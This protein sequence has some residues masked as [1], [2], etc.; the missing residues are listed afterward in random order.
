MYFNLAAPYG[1]YGNRGLTEDI[2]KQT[3]KTKAVDAVIAAPMPPERVGVA[4]P[5]APGQPVVI[6]AT[7][8][9]AKEGGSAAHPKSAGLAAAATRG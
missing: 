3:P 8:A 2:R 4:T 7:A 1:K 9:D 6:D 5:L